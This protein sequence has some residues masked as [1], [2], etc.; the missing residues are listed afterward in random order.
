MNLEYAKELAHRPIVDVHHFPEDGVYGVASEGRIFLIPDTLKKPR[1]TDVQYANYFMGLVADQIDGIQASNGGP[2]IV[3]EDIY[4]QGIFIEPE[5]QQGFTADM[6]NDVIVDIFQN[7]FTIS[8]DG[9]NMNEIINIAVVE[10]VVMDYLNGAIATIFPSKKPTSGFKQDESDEGTSGSYTFNWKTGKWEKDDDEEDDICGGCPS[11]Q[12]LWQDFE[13]YWDNSQTM[14]D[15]VNNIVQDTGMA[16]YSYED[17]VGEE[18][19]GQVFITNTYVNRQNMAAAN[20]LNDIFTGL[21]NN[22][23]MTD[24][25]GYWNTNQ[26]SLMQQYGIDAKTANQITVMVDGMAGDVQ[27][28]SV[29]TNNVFRP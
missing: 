18:A 14:Q 2:L 24:F 6:M 21:Q 3:V 17:I 25:Q 23:T 5:I 19:F 12:E 29:M 11:R 26:N 28:R 4:G 16:T 15:I 22:M 9:L 10:G 27:F 8:P 7:G 13:G 20:V 1:Q